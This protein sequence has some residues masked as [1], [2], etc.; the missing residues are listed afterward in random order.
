MFNEFNPFDTHLSDMGLDFSYEQKCAIIGSFLVLAQVDG[1]IDKKELQ[2]I[3]STADYIHLKIDSTL[4]NK[5]KAL[6]NAGLESMFVILSSLSE[7]QKNWYISQVHLLINI[8]GKMGDEELA[9]LTDV[10]KA[11]NLT[12]DDYTQIRARR[13]DYD[14]D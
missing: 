4:S 8:D 3:E 11:M 7:V 10:L 1:D 13:R 9:C 14:C 2:I 12:F 6:K 5:L